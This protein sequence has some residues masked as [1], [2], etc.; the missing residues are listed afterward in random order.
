VGWHVLALLCDAIQTYVL[1]ELLLGAQAPG[2][3]R[4]LLVAVAVAALEQMFFF[5]S[6]SLGTLEVIRF[7]VLSA[8]GIAQIYGLAFGLVARLHNVFWNGLGLVAYAL[9]T[10]R[11]PGVSFGTSRSRR[12]PLSEGVPGPGCECDTRTPLW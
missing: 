12:L 11:I 8:V 4:S 6:G 1:L 2:L 3:A 5:V 7:T 10:Q 9:C